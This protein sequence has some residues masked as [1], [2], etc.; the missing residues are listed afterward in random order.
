LINKKAMDEKLRT[1]ASGGI[2]SNALNSYKPPD[3]AETEVL[4]AND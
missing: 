3:I 1:I 4:R 2:A